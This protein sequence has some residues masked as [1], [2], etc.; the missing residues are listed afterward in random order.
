MTFEY[1][2]D[3]TGPSI[4]QQVS[5][6]EPA[7]EPYRAT[8]DAMTADCSAIWVGSKT[9]SSRKAFDWREESSSH[10]WI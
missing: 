5:V 7:G 2:Q 8:V 4:G 6:E 9:V 1:K 10:P 3:W